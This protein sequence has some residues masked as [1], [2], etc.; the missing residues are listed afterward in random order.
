MCH[1][2]RKAFDDKTTNSTH[3]CKA[4]EE[5][6]FEAETL[7]RHETEL[8]VSNANKALAIE[9]SFAESVK[10]G[11]YRLAFLVRD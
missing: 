5:N 10:S 3:H 4:V 7:E 6:E 11:H 8:N 9:G 1:I 2:T